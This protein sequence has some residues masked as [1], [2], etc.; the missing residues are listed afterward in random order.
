MKR[1]GA[2]ALTNNLNKQKSEK[3]DDKLFWW[4]CLSHIFLVTIETKLRVSE[5]VNVQY[6]PTTILEEKKREKI[7]ETKKK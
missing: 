2:Q 6:Q 5:T 4:Y 7:S 1:N 3:K